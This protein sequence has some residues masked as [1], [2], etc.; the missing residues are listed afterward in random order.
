VLR[1]LRLLRLFGKL[2]QLKQ[3]VT[4]VALSIVPTLQALVR[5]RR[6]QEQS[7][8]QR[9]VSF[10]IYSPASS[11]AHHLNFTP[12][13]TRA[14]SAHALTYTLACLCAHTL[15]YVRPHALSRT[16]AHNQLIGLIFIFIYALFG[17][18]FFAARSEVFLSLPPLLHLLPSLHTFSPTVPSD[19][20]ISCSLAHSL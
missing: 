5:A 15:T 2:Q 17:L 16:R 1:A 14:P 4:A 6:L 13:H 10:R 11:N 12:F 18:Q 19:I 7:F 3:I 20:Y 9:L 8:V